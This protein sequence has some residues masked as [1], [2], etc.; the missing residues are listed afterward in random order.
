MKPGI[1]SAS[2][3]RPSLLPPDRVALLRR[4]AA[5]ASF[6]APLV[7]TPAAA[8][9]LLY[10]HSVVL[11]SRRKG[12]KDPESTS[13]P[14]AKC[15]ICAREFAKRSKMIRHMLSVHADDV[16]KVEL[17]QFVNHN[18]KKRAVNRLWEGEEAVET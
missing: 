15:N 13:K 5:S 9:D 14:G 17:A 7:A 10:F 11:G 6:S 4:A 8:A 12:D 16:H 1:S 2:G 3:K 18:I